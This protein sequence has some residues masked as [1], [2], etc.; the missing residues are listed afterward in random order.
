[1]ILYRISKLK[2]Q[3][4][5]GPGKRRRM[6]AI[7]MQ[8]QVM[9]PVTN[10]S[11]SRN[12]KKKTAVS[13][14]CFQATLRSLSTSNWLGILW[15]GHTRWSNLRFLNWSLPVSMI[16]FTWIQFWAYTQMVKWKFI[17]IS[18]QN[19]TTT[20]ILTVCHFSL[21]QLPTAKQRRGIVGP[22]NWPA[23]S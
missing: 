15:S 16:C 2:S 22:T 18:N 21:L 8:Y 6:V 3:R 11:E 19:F 20:F 14:E 12:L 1:M 4:E 17:C 13:I 5:P 9:H 23:R 10:L 7:F